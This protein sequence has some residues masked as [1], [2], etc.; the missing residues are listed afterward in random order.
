[1]KL[2]GRRGRKRY[3]G[4]LDILVPYLHFE[5]GQARDE[6][7]AKVK[8]GGRNPDI[9]GDPAAQKVWWSFDAERDFRKNFD[10]MSFVILD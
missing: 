7:F 2:L 5:D 3:K 6:A 10:C 1:M 8:D 4:P 9:W